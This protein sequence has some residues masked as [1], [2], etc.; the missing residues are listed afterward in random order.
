MGFLDKAKN[1]ARKGVVQSLADATMSVVDKTTSGE[2]G[3]SPLRR[4]IREYGL[5]GTNAA[6]ALK[7]VEDAVGTADI[8]F[9]WAGWIAKYGVSGGWTPWEHAVGGV[10][11]VAYCV[12]SEGRVL[13]VNNDG[14]LLHEHRPAPGDRPEVK[15]VNQV[16]CALVPKSK[17]DS[18]R[19]HASKIYTFIG[20]MNV[21]L[22][23][24]NMTEYAEYQGAVVT[25]PAS[26]SHAAFEMVV[27]TGELDSIIAALTA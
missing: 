16:I 12:L 8:D 26:D 17:T 23:P 14:E 19:A 11:Q 24:S 6:S 21:Q 25:V 9:F 4:F 3:P 1:V 5:S 18:G 13:M 7:Q 2:D 10:A 15:L 20:N 27:L 22:R